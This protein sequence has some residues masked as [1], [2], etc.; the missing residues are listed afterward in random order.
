MKKTLLAGI[1]SLGLLLTGV[2]AQAAPEERDDEYKS[3]PVVEVEEIEDYGPVGT[4]VSQNSFDVGTWTDGR[5]VMIVQGGTKSWRTALAVVDPLTGEM[6][7]ETRIMEIMQSLSPETGPDGKFYIP[8]YPGDYDT[9]NLVRFDPQTQEIEDLGIGIP[10]ETHIARMQW[11][12]D[13]LWMGTYPNAHVQSYDLNTGEYTDH[14]RVDENEWYA[15]SIAHDGDHTVYVG[16]EGT[17]RIIK[18]DLETGEKEDLPKP[19]DGAASDYTVMLMKYAEGFIFA[20]YGGSSMWHAY[21]TEAGEWVDQLRS[22]AS[23]P[24][25]VDPDTGKIFFGSPDGLHYFDFEAREFVLEG[26][27][28]KLSG[29]LAGGGIQLMDLQHE[30]WPGLTVVGQG[31]S[32][33][34]W[35]YNPERQYGEVQNDAEL[36]ESGQL[37]RAMHLEDGQLYYGMGINSGMLATFDIESKEYETRSPFS[38]QQIHNHLTGSDGAIY[39]ATYTSAG[40]IRYDPDEPYAWQTNP[41]QIFDF[42][43]EEGQDRIFGLTELDGKLIMG[44]TGQRGMADGVIAVYDMATEELDTYIAPL[45]G[46]QITAFTIADGKA[47]GGTSIVTPGED[48]VAEESLIFELDPADGSIVWQDAPLP[49]NETVAELVARDD[50]KVWGLT[51]DDVLFLYD[52]A[53]RE[54]LEEIPVGPGGSHDGYS[55]INQG[56]DGHWYGATVSGSMFRLQPDTGE[57]QR[58]EEYGVVIEQAPDGTLFWND[59]VSTFSGTMAEEPE[60]VGDTTVSVAPVT[61]TGRTANVWGIVPTGEATVRTQVQLADGRWAT[62]QTAR[63]NA[64]GWYAIELTYGKTTAG[65]LNWRVVVDHADGTQEIS[66]PVTQTRAQRPVASTAG[67]KPVGQTSYVWGSVGEAGLPVWSEVRLAD[68]RWVKSQEVVSEDGGWYK[69]ELTYGKQKAGLYRWRVAVD[70]PDVG[71]IRSE[72]VTFRRL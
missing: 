69:I 59:A 63:S 55:V 72:A 6:L 66:E 48:P 18:W 64:D 51:N 20:R 61:V 62:S 30:D 5:P 44:T 58:F 54:I 3:L 22:T 70:H 15:R 28:Q 27:G 57:V 46:H 4:E 13:T 49:G 1:T 67:S 26:W 19:P 50:G 36:P 52:P 12:G 24:T 9:T 65:E 39:M 34:I 71:V 14:G 17:A 21:D 10:G 43:K 23:M 40:I 41:K 38:T 2:A 42:D 68:G 32:G 31:R 45:P 60:P 37:I 8:G 25:D 53:S 7:Y 29:S 16:T 56:V 47:I 33:G 35:R 11:E